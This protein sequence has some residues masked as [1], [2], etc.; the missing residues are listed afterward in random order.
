MLPDT[1][2]RLCWRESEWHTIVTSIYVVHLHSC[3]ICA[4]ASEPGV[5]TSGTCTPKSSAL[6]TPLLLVWRRL[7]T[8]LMY[9]KDRQDLALRSHS[10]VA[11]SR[12]RG[13]PNS[14]VS[15][16]SRKRVT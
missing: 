14:G 13:T 2:T 10:R 4:M 12:P 5:W 9:Q 15:L 8:L 1:L 11:G 16:S 7:I 6:S 3:R